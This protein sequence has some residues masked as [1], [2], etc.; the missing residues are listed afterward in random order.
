M[1]TLNWYKFYYLI[2]I[3][4]MLELYAMKV[5]RTVLKGFNI[6]KYYLALTDPSN[7]YCS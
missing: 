5:A 1:L 6:V 3:E 7:F 2:I 4:C